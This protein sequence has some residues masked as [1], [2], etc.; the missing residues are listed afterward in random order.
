[1][2][3]VSTLKPPPS[4]GSASST[5]RSPSFR[6]SRLRDVLAMAMSKSSSPSMSNI[7]APHP[8]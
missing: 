7:V 5:K 1:M 4:P 3:A 2:D 8:A 6:H